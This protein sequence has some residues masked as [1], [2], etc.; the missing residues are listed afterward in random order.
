M[1]RGAVLRGAHDGVP[2]TG[3]LPRAPA[4]CATRHR[5]GPQGWYGLVGLGVCM[6]AHRR[7]PRPVDRG[8]VRAALAALRASG[9]CRALC[10]H[11]IGRLLSGVLLG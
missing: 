4:T 5:A 1:T 8:S 10:A 6:L 11:L 9:P 3:A 2:G 7:D